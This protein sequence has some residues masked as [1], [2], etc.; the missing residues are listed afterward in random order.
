M[1]KCVRPLFLVEGR[2]DCIHVE[3]AQEAF[4]GSPGAS[5][6][7]S[8]A[9]LLVLTE[10]E[11]TQHLRDE[12]CVSADGV[13]AEDLLFTDASSRNWEE[14]GLNLLTSMMLLPELEGELLLRHYGMD[15]EPQTLEQ[16]E[17]SFGVPLHRLEVI[18]Q[19]ALTRLRA[20]LTGL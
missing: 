6:L 10:V 17:R 18:H 14:F 12:E 1:S 16:L 20:H 4:P 9:W 5:P 11:K 2:L 7:P 3:A 8:P 15:G 19:R 13:S